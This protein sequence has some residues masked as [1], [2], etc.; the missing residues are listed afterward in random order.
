MGLVRFKNLTKYHYLTYPRI[1]PVITSGTAEKPNI[2][3]ASWTT[4]LSVRPPLFG[5]SVAPRRY[6]CELIRKYKA[7]GVC[8]LPFKYVDIVLGVGSVSGREV[9]KFKHFGLR[10]FVG[11]STGVPILEDSVSALE[12]RLVKEVEVGDHIFFVGEVVAAWL[13]EGILRGSIFDVSKVR[14]VYYIGDGFFTTNSSEVVKPQ[15]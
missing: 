2:M 13:R 10:F 11:D 7:F 9:D 6:S 1:T 15:A 5:V 4:P 8:F 3:A 12:C 14:H